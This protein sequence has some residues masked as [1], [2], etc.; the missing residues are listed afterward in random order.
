M[1]Y[2]PHTQKDVPQALTHRHSVFLSIHSFPLSIF[3][4]NFWYLPTPLLHIYDGKKHVLMVSSLQNVE[5]VK[6]EEPFKIGKPAT[7][8]VPCTTQFSPFFYHLA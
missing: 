5:E 4:E 1:Q 8:T 7:S 6:K 2:E 3:L